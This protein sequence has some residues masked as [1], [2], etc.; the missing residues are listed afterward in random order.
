MYR[1]KILTLFMVITS[2]IGGCKGSNSESSDIR[3]TPPKKEISIY[4]Q[5]TLQFSDG[6]R[7]IIVDLRNR[8][9]SENNEDIII[10]DV[11]SLN[12]DNENCRI[13][14]INGLSFTTITNDI[15]IC[16]YEYKVKPVDSSSVGQGRAVS[17]IIVT[18]GYDKGEYLPPI[19]S[20]LPPS[21]ETEHSSII[22][23]K[24]E[25]Q[26]PD[27]FIVD[28]VNLIGDTESHELGSVS[29]NDE[30]ITYIAPVDTTGVVRIYYSIVNKDSGIIRPGI[31]YIAIG[32]SI[33]SNPVAEPESKIEAMSILDDARPSINVERYTR[34]PDNDSLQ[35]ISLYS[36]QG[37]IENINGLEFT[38]IPTETG[39]NYITYIVSDH[40]GGYAVGIL[41]SEV[42]SFLNIYDDNQDITFLAPLTIADLT[43][44]QGISSGDYQEL[45][46]TGPKGIYPI[47]DTQLALSYCTTRG[48]V[49]PTKEQYMDLFT[50]KLENTPVQD[51]DYKWISG[52]PYVAID[53]FVSLSNGLEESSA[54][55][56]YFSCVQY[57]AGPE[58]YSFSRS[59]YLGE[60]D[61]DV[62]ITANA[63]T[64][65]GLFPL[66]EESYTLDAE[67]SHT[68]PEGLA[69]QINVSVTGRKVNVSIDPSIKDIIKNVI[70]SVKDPEHVQ[71]NISE[72]KVIYGISECPRDSSVED[73]LWN[74]CVPVVTYTGNSLRMTGP[75]TYRTLTNMGMETSNM[76]K[77]FK[78]LTNNPEYWG[79]KYSEDNPRPMF[80][81]W[82]KDGKKFAQNYCDILSSMYIGGRNN[83]VAEVPNSY[84]P[85]VEP[86]WRP[87]GFD[88]TLI[89]V[90]SSVTTLKKLESFI[91]NSLIDPDG[92][93]YSSFSLPFDKNRNMQLNV[94]RPKYRGIAYQPYW[95][96]QMF[97]CASMSNN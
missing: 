2:F 7:P 74:D 81:E 52:A 88:L 40:N 94:L 13:T 80:N 55:L 15:G 90:E 89:P 8:I 62:L 38:Y 45:G 33:N 5:D 42:S 79:T 69:E 71:G 23:D 86:G 3:P 9:K 46:D 78:K 50:E 1:I 30:S 19:S 18:E 87:D 85:E 53:G 39:T 14:D 82:Q 34:D 77:V 56:G 72:T 32:Q 68:M 96:A 75:V 67:V 36:S 41:I 27:G 93:P 28:N 51:T 76:P 22:F 63:D 54:E 57:I 11:K 25:I 47:F 83:W 6:K 92:V 12:P 73:M 10:S 17:Q 43:A 37:I 70:V 20:T 48:L 4:T 49:L 66:P 21:T 64:I 95:L 61:E 24:S 29:F 59:S 65:Y 35:L 31:I 44:T 97:V 91:K 60:F 26:I 58:E 16:R 84:N